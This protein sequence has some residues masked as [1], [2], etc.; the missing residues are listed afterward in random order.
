VSFIAVSDNLCEA[1][2]RH[3]VRKVGLKDLVKLKK[4]LLARDNE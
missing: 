2:K 3:L 1:V 4:I